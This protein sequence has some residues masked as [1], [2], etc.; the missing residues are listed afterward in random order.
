[1]NVHLK[2][3]LPVLHIAIFILLFQATFT[4]FK[5]SNSSVAGGYTTVV[6]TLAGTKSVFIAFDSDS[7][8][9][10]AC[11]ECPAC[12]NL[13]HE[14][15]WFPV[16]SFSSYWPVLSALYF[17]ADL[18]ITKIPNLLFSSYLSRAPPV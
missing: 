7:Q 15:N 13:L 4:F 16:V 1:M 17:V 9:M 2:T 3:K 12:I 10:D 8:D 18:N 6:C 11:I 14:D 5:V